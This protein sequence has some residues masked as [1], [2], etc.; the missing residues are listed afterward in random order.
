MTANNPFSQLDMFGAPPAPAEP[1]APQKM[2]KAEPLK[3]A[4]T[5][6][7]GLVFGRKAPIKADQ[8]E[9]ARGDGARATTAPPPAPRRQITDAPALL[10]SSVLLAFLQACMAH[11]E[12]L[13]RQLIELEEVTPP[14]ALDH[15]RLAN[16]A[17][18]FVESPA[19]RAAIGLRALDLLVEQG[20][21]IDIAELEL[22]TPAPGATNT[23]SAHP[24]SA[25]A[26]P[27]DV[28]AA[29]DSQVLASAVPLATPKVRHD[30]NAWYR[31]TDRHK[32]IVPRV[33]IIGDQKQPY[34]PPSFDF[35]AV[36][37]GTPFT[38]RANADDGANTP[39]KTFQQHL[40]YCVPT[41]DAKQ[42]LLV[43][44]AA[45]SDALWALAEELRA[46]GSYEAALT[47]A[48]GA[49]KHPQ[50]L[51][52]TAITCEDPDHNTYYWTNWRIP[53]PERKTVKRHTP[54]MIQ[55]GDTTGLRMLGGVFCC[56]DDAV[57]ERVQAAHA[58]VASS[59]DH[60]LALLKQLG[61]YEE[62]IAD[63][64]YGS[65]NGSQPLWEDPRA[66]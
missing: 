24:H 15:H 4:T 48:G 10:R 19:L 66:V 44:R 65:S 17:R 55:L 1:A 25:A 28:V 29:S 42:Q 30:E 50:P 40:A 56:A 14:E 6:Q 61:T 63:N 59:R 60:L 2:I 26:Q 12:E 41:D 27:G 46:V 9:K 52:P 21:T 58:K 47:T 38:I 18:A 37:Y 39:A 13:H 54:K 3:P 22:P 34:V 53:Q 36:E 7:T 45:F 64:R 11:A 20:G 32:P 43:A 23:T 8:K 51:T 62:A 16:D 57:W 5:T 49:T 35:R 31:K 33:L